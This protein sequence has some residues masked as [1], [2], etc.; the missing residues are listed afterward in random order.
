M[1]VLIASHNMGKITEFKKIL[2]NL[3]FEFMTLNDL[4]EVEEPEETGLTLNENS[5]IKAKYYFDSFKIPVIADD[6]GLFI[7]DLNGEPGI[8]AARYSGYGD[9][10]NRKLVLQKL[11]GKMS[12]AY[13]ETVLT[14]YDGANVITA[15]GIM[16][17]K[18]AYSI[19]G[20]NGFGYDPIFYLPEFGMTSA[21]ISPE[22]KNEIS[23]RG[24]A[25]RLIKDRIN[26][27]INC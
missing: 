13:F 5:L 1:K 27:S 22:Q 16:E 25:L 3:G 4:H 2:N 18:I 14:F 8:N 26:E 7:E 15:N 11:N 21:S 9:K 23:H 24:K 19:E 12:N 6:T 17:G 10:E 20:T